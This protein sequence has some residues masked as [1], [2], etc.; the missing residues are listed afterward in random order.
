M[1]RADLIA[2]VEWEG[3]LMDA[4][5]YGLFDDETLATLPLVLRQAIRDMITLLPILAT[6]WEKYESGLR[7]ENPNDKGGSDDV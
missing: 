1:T 3:G 5:D 4:I 7:L 6:E 2:K